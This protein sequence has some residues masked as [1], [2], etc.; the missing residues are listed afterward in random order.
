MNAKQ[1]KLNWW[2]R[3]TMAITFAEAGEHDTARDIL[4]APGKKPEQRTEE[5]KDRRPELRV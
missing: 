3:I 2:D 5:Q 4:N 1:K